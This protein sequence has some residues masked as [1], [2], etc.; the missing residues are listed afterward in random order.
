MKK[1]FVILLLTGG[2]LTSGCSDWLDVLPKDKQSTDMYWQSAEDVESI[3]AQGYSCMRNCIPYMI[4]WGELR[5][6]SVIVP[7]RATENGRVQNF[8]VLPN[9]SRVAW[10]TFYQAI[11]MANAV[12]KYAPGVME[13]DESYHESQMNSHCTE[14]YF[15]RGLMYLYLV[16]NY[17]EVP[18]ITEPYVDDEMPTNV[19]KSSEQEILEQ[20]KSDMRTALDTNAAKEFFE[21]SWATKGRSTK[22]ALYALMA[23][24]CLW[25]EDYDECVTYADYLINATSGRRPVFMSVPSQWFQIFY[26]GN[27]NESIFEL[28]FD[29]ATYYQTNNCPTSIMPYSTSSTNKTYMYSEAMTLRLYEESLK[30]A[31]RTYFGS[32]APREN[33]HTP[34][35]YDDYPDNAIIWKYSGMGTNSLIAIRGGNQMDA[36]YIIYRMA[37]V[38][39]MKAEALIWKGKENWQEAVDIIN[40]IRTRAN[41][42]EK[43][44]AL[45]EEDESSMMENY[46]LPERNIELAAEGKRWYD[47]IRYA[48][49]KNYAHKSAFIALVQQ[50]NTTA[51]ASWIRSVLQNEYAWYLPIHADE[52]E[53]NNL[54]VQNP[55][56]GITGNN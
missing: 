51:N 44:I 53:N 41:L 8:Q 18:L 22:W 3:L 55:Y 25:A 32:C 6:G 14:A 2:L 46:L 5:G 9:N 20:I 33:L 16:R 31:V 48:K 13:K 28:Q 35:Y 47:M 36:N 43:T 56:Y 27:S 1:I 15:I 26:P 10:G 7:S 38:M 12:L 49:S 34:S 40:Q 24:T 54:L 37:D 50:Y 23:E 4:D 21:D 17:G 45:D 42:P 30:E 11:G 19:A 39:L 29:G 52:I